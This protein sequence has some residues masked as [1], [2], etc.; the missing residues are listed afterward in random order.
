MPR[1]ILAF[2]NPTQSFPSSPDL[3]YEALTRKGTDTVRDGPA[4]LLLASDVARLSGHPAQAVAP[5][6]ELVARYSR[7]PR[8]PLA[9][10][11]LGRVL[12]DEVGRPREAAEAFRQVRRLDEEGHLAEDALARETE[13]WSLA[14]EL[15]LARERALE[16]LQ[17]YPAG[18]RAQSVRRHGGLD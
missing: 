7:D 8:A 16:Y 17:R 1:D 18:V 10:F 3:A 13:A 15:E 4:D 14:G 6:R 5:L 12:L 9:A 11:T 2:H